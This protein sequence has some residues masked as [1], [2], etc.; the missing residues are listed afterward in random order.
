MTEKKNRPV[1]SPVI[2]TGKE[3]LKASLKI[4]GWLNETLDAAAKRA[5]KQVSR[6]AAL[7]LLILHKNDEAQS[8]KKLLQAY[9][10]WR[11][12]PKS[13]DVEESLRVAL[14]HLIRIDLVT[15]GGVG[16]VAFSKLEP[17]DLQRII[18]KLLEKGLQPI[19]K[20]RLTDQASTRIDMMR[21]TIDQRLESV[22]HV[23]SARNRKVFDQLIKSSLPY[24]PA[25]LANELEES[26]S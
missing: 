6:D 20:I 14:G 15:V 25:K 11:V 3:D 24:P 1:K 22:R 21:E 2:D 23:L 9:R 4:V 13:M 12:S 7:T 16:D 8:G 26:A 17:R 19:K 10:S 18:G 5:G